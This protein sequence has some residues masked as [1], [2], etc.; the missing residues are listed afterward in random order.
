MEYF[1]F[2]NIFSFVLFGIDKLYAKGRMK[3]ISEKTLIF[4]SFMGGGMGSLLGMK[5][6]RHKTLHMKFRILIPISAIV[7][8]GLMYLTY[9][10]LFSGQLV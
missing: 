9:T 8:A 1:I 10:K 3:R 7:S 5:I 4:I 6:F 2:V